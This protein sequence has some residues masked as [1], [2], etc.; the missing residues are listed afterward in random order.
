MQEFLEGGFYFLKGGGGPLSKCVILP[1]LANFSD[2][3]VVFQP[4]RSPSPDPPLQYE[5]LTNHEKIRTF[6]CVRFIPFCTLVSLNLSCLSV[7]P[8]L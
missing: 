1:F 7:C 5:E 6:V 4:P 8:K 2:E 3:K